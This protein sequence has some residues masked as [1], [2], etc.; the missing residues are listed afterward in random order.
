MMMSGVTDMSEL[1]ELTPGLQC[2]LR[3][4]RTLTD[5][6]MHD[7]LEEPVLDSIRADHPEWARVDGNCQPCLG[8]Y[9]RLLGERLSRPV[10]KREAATAR[11]SSWAGKLFG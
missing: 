4:G 9:R 1:I 3:C 11:A 2:C 6:A 8:E 5:R 10:K 7:S